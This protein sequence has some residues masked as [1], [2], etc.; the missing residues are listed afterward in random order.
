MPTFSEYSPISGRLLHIEIG[1]VELILIC[2]SLEGR[3]MPH[4]TVVA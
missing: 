2:V 4:Y 3:I 1:Q